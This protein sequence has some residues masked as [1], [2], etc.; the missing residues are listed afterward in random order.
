MKNLIIVFALALL[1]I[2]GYAT[3]DPHKTPKQELR[4]EIIALLD[5]RPDI[6]VEE[7]YVKAH[8]VFTLNSKNQIVVLTIDAK[9]GLSEVESYVKSRLNYKKLN[10]KSS[11]KGLNLF[12]MDLKILKSES[13]KA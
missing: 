8:I 11:H 5:K 3:N 4:N 9:E 6:E 2:Q 12:E 13:S 7:A 1:G 10:F